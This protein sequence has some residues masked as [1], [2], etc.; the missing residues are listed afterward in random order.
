MKVRFTNSDYDPEIREAFF[1]SSMSGV[2][3]SQLQERD[4]MALNQIGNTK[5]M[6]RI[7]KP[8]IY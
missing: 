7:M 8:K 3:Y 5:G 2:F 1:I 4:K 6:N